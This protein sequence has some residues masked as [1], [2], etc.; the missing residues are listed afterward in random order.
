MGPGAR[1]GSGL[2][3]AGASGENRPTRRLCE[4]QSRLG[5]HILTS[6][7]TKHALNAYLNVKMPQ[8]LRNKE[9]R[10]LEAEFLFS[11]N[12]F[13]FLSGLIAVGSTFPFT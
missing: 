4:G 6:H 2:S 8:H 5:V 7:S 10:R 13:L 12:A 1:A 9:K 11:G 3:W